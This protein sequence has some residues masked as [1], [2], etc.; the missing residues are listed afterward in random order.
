M[1]RHGRR[2]AFGTARRCHAT[3]RGRRNLDRPDRGGV[4]RPR[5]A[6]GRSRVILEIDEL[7]VKLADRTLVD[8][9][10]LTVGAAESVGLVG[11]SGSGKS[12]T[13]KAA[14]RLLPRGLKATGAITFDG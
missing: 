3:E 2:R 6:A 4:Q 10:S 13:I 12:L 5:R 7:T 11:E 14:M 8:G 9:V 1:G